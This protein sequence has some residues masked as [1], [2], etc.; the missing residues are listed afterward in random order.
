MD[1][2]LDQPTD[3]AAYL[4]RVR[5]LQDALRQ[6]SPDI[7]A[8]RQLPPDIAEMLRDAG[9][10]AAAVPRDWGGPELDPVTIARAVELLAEA[11][12]SAAW[13]AMIGMDTGFLSAYLEDG[14]G[15]ALFQDPTMASVFVVAPGGVATEVDGGYRVTGRWPFAS[16][17][18]HAAV[19]GLGTILMGEEGPRMLPSGMPEMRIIAIPAEQAQVLDTWTTTGLRG[20]GSH[21]VAVQDLFVPEAH[22]FAGLTKP[23]LRAGALYIYPVLFTLKLGAV[24]L[25]I[26]RAAIDDVMNLAANK[27]RAG[28]TGV[29]KDED[30]LHAEIGRME[31]AWGQARAFYYGALGELWAEI[32][33]GGM[34]SRLAQARAHAAQVGAWERCVQVVDTMYRSAGSSAIYARGTLDRRVRDI[35]AMGQHVLFHT[36]TS[37]VMG[38][39]FLGLPNPTFLLVDRA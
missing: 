16:G 26:A 5:G 21:D 30:W 39:E 14:A 1:A 22:T 10:F 31:I 36:D 7:E 29:I 4:E 28:S 27:R 8:A 25:G 19:Y 2:T 15:R 20:S 34:P 33:S 17:C 32:Q 37:R 13:C 18:T 12:G 9:L 3:T 23:M 38:R 35:H 6:A 24:P 11:D